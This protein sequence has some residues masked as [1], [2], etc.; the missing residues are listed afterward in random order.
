[1]LSRN[2]IISIL[3]VGLVVSGVL[4]LT[5]YMIY[6][7]IAHPYKCVQTSIVTQILELQY[8]EAMIQLADGRKVVVDQATLKPGDTFCLKRERT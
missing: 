2:K 6:Q 5:S 7:D 3:P 4:G 8:R 1:M